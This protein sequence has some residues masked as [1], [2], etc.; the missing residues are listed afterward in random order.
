ML[1]DQNFLVG[2]NADIKIISASTTGTAA[3][4]E[5]GGVECD[6]LQIIDRIFSSVLDLI[7]I[8]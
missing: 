7:F 4:L 6:T 1:L 3:I 5:L 2:R 8:K